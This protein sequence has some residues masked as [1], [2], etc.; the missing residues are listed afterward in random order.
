M[1]RGAARNAGPSF[2][3][4]GTPI[5]DTPGAGVVRLNWVTARR[6]APRVIYE[7]VIK[8]TEEI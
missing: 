4:G 2:D 3:E 6:F 1:R 8:K 5:T 7:R